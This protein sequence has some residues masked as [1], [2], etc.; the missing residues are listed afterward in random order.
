[1]V[2]NRALTLRPGGGMYKDSRFTVPVT[3]SNLIGKTPW[4][5]IYLKNHVTKLLVG[6]V[7]TSKAKAKEKIIRVVIQDEQMQVHSLLQHE[8]QI[9]IGSKISLS[10]YFYFFFPLWAQITL[11]SMSKSLKILQIPAA[12]LS[13][14]PAAGWCSL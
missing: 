1:M 12:T 10:F 8:C 11:G 13:G 9:F 3:E 5:V 14:M 7:K 6:I 4:S 2:F